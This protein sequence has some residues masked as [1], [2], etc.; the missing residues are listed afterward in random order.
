MK[1]T[2]IVSFARTPFGSFLGSIKDVSATDLGALVIREAVSRAGI[3]GGS[4]DYAL[5]GMVV[6]AGAGQIPSRQATIKAGL[7]VEV[8]SDTIGKVCASSLR[9]VNL[10]DSL[11][12]AGDAEIVLAGGMENMSATPYL[13]EK[14]R[15][16]YR[17]GDGK[18]VDAMVRDG[19]W[20]AIHDVHMGVHGGDVADEFGIGREPQDEWALR[21]HELAVKAIDEGKLQEE[22][23]PVSVP[24]RKGDPIVFDTDELPRRNASLEA[25]AKLP[26]VFKKGACVTAGNAPPIS[27]GASALVLMS[28]EKAEQ[29]GVKPLA[30]VVSQGAASAKAPYIATVPALAGKKA[31]EKAGMTAD[32]L[33]LIEVNEAFAAVALTSIKLGGWNPDVVNVNGGAIAYGH[34]IGASGGRILMTLLTEMKR[35][36][37]RYGMATICSGAAQGEATIIK[38]EE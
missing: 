24:Q 28:R 6:Q 13:M 25:L 15:T 7:P 36:S 17:M 35:R 26:P 34:P 31:L 10:G 38:L 29:L 9:A 30:S 18:L 21:S 37:A 20:C 16:G 33:D 12:R 5:M 14:A 23:V 11:I 8:P 19:L 2:V 1:E 32:Q 3:E 22:I 4:I 27:D